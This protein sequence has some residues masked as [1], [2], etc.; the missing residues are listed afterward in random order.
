MCACPLFA[1]FTSVE[2]WWI[3]LDLAIDSSWET[4]G[5]S[6][7]WAIDQAFN[8]TCVETHKRGRYAAELITALSVLM[9]DSSLWVTEAF[10]P[11][12]PWNQQNVTWCLSAAQR[13]NHFPGLRT[14]LLAKD[15]ALWQ[16]PPT[17]SLWIQMNGTVFTTAFNGKT[18]LEASSFIRG[19]I[20]AL[21]FTYW[22]RP[23]GTVTS[24]YNNIT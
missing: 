13:E 20:K 5:F 11:G 10:S 16:H 3:S 9:N 22:N 17:P 12:P 24:G 8:N 15:S 14:S 1:H 21:W 4:Y 23:Q 7:M 2:L 18:A 19:T 6:G